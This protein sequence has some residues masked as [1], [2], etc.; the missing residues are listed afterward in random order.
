MPFPFR[1]CLCT[2]EMYGADVETEKEV[3]QQYVKEIDIEFEELI[4]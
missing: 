2:G 4:A 1:V 3:G